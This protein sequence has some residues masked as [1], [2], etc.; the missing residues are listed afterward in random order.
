MTGR[1]VPS[2]SAPGNCPGASEGRFVHILRVCEPLLVREGSIALAVLV[3]GVMMA[4]IDTTIIVLAMPVMMQA[5]GVDLA[6][7]TWVLLTYVIVVTV[8]STQL[9]RLGDIKGRARMFDVGMLVFALGSALAGASSDAGL[10]LAFRGVQAVGGALMLSNS[11]ALISDYFSHERRGF[12]F[13]W[14]T[15]GWNIGA[16]TGIMLGGFLTTFLSWRWDF[17]ITAPLGVVGFGLGVRY[18]KGSQE[19]VSRGF[20]LLGSAVLGV[21]LTLISLGALNYPVEGLGGSTLSLL[22]SGLLIFAA[23]LLLERRRKDPVLDLSLL[24]IRLFGASTSAAFLQFVANY[25]VLFLL[26]MYLQGVRS[27]DPFTASLYLVPGYVVGSGVGALGG[28]LADMKDPR[29]IA[30]AGLVLQMLSYLLYFFTLSVGVSLGV[31]IVGTV[32]TSTGGALF[33]SSNGKLVMEDVPKDKY[34]MASGTFRTVNNM[35][36]IMS[37][38]VAVVAAASAIPKELAFQIFA[39]TTSLSA[40]LLDPFVVSLRYAFIAS[41]SIMAGAVVLSWTRRG[42]EGGA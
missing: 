28:R 29:V 5:L 8:L 22:G 10:L 13:G 16:V 2:T 26:T 42:R 4:G 39:G 32:L 18:L 11:T 24:R 40:S 17:Y 21:S 19:I 36:M 41:A 1:S 12:A 31:V 9:G 25:A 23:F 34:G 14:T 7:I 3:L 15:F 35:G 33:F 27:L 6:S 20:D 30:T 38:A 37:F